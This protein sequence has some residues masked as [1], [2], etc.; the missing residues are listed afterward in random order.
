MEASG[1]TYSEMLL[2]KCKIRENFIKI[3]KTDF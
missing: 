2:T 3:P 1:Y